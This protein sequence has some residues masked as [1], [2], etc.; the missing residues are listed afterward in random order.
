MKTGISAGASHPGSTA[1]RLPGWR[2]FM[3]SMI[4]AFQS[5]MKG[6]V[7]HHAARMCV[8]KEAANETA[9]EN[10]NYMDS[11]PL[12]AKSPRPALARTWE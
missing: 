2:A 10:A 6:L 3:D 8:E 7:F 1:H 4:R 12:I 5:V 11:R 9:P